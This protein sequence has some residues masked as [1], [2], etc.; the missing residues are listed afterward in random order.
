A[1]PAADGGSNFVFEAP[2]LSS[3]VVRS[4]SQAGFSNSPTSFSRRLASLDTPC[5][6]SAGGKVAAHSSPILADF[7]EEA[8]KKVHSTFRAANQRTPKDSPRSASSTPDR[9]PGVLLPASKKVMEI[10]NRGQVANGEKPIQSLGQLGRFPG[11]GD[12]VDL[13]EK[14]LSRPDKMELEKQRRA[15]LH[16]SRHSKKPQGVLRSLIETNQLG[17]SS[18]ES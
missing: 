1:A 9:V 5:S 2:K 8:R 6:P 4:K 18:M 15:R 10:I 3:H 12:P 7:Q 16:N 14:R 11:F 13:P 17:A